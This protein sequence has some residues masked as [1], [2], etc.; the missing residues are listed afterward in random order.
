MIIYTT[1][2][3]IMHMSHRAISI[4]TFQLHVMWTHLNKNTPLSSLFAKAQRIV[5]A[6]GNNGYIMIFRQHFISSLQSDHYIIVVIG[7]YLT[8]SYIADSCSQCGDINT[9]HE[10]ITIYT[11]WYP[12]TKSAMTT[13]QVQTTPPTDHV[14]VELYG[15]FDPKCVKVKISPNINEQGASSVYYDLCWIWSLTNA[16]TFKCY[17]NALSCSVIFIS[18]SKYC[19]TSQL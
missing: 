13:D 5:N 17:C 11:N 8:I 18:F 2:T 10:D 16:I 14:Y 6:I 12:P 9:M 7:S 3:T 15:S 19:A 1:G 4:N